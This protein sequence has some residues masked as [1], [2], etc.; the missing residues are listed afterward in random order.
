MTGLCGDRGLDMMK[1]W[2]AYILAL[3]SYQNTPTVPS[4]CLHVVLSGRFVVEIQMISNPLLLA[5]L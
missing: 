2:S 5:V 4:T 3:A 1:G